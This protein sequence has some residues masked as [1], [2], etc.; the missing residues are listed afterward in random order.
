MTRR[1]KSKLEK[2]R[3][4][5]EVKDRSAISAVQLC[6]NSCISPSASSCTAVISI[7]V[8]TGELHIQWLRRRFMDQRNRFLTYESRFYVPLPPDTTHTYAEPHG[9]VSG[10]LGESVKVEEDQDD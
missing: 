7:S 8:H 2:V 4:S 1:K 9:D 5:E 3:Q 6:T 10:D